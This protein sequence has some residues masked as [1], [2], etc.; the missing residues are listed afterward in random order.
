MV[1]TMAV[2]LAVQLVESLVGKLDLLWV[3]K[4]AVWL[5]YLMGI[6]LAI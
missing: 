2:D 5:V 4:L 3:E 1:D 6:S